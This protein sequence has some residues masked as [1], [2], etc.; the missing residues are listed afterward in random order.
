[1]GHSN[2]LHMQDKEACHLVCFVL[3]HRRVLYVSV[4]AVFSSLTEH[5][6]EAGNKPHTRHRGG[7]YDQGRWTRTPFHQSK[8]YVYTNTLI[9]CY[10]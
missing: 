1:M 8:G 4:L 10:Y 2:W 7:E 5:A 9:N 3:H 6:Q